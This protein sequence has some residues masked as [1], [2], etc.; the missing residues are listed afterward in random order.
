MEIGVHE[1]KTLPYSEVKTVTLNFPI[2]PHATCGC[3]HTLTYT[4]THTHT[5]THTETP[6]NLVC[7]RP[8]LGGN[9][10]HLP[11]QTNCHLWYPLGKSPLEVWVSPETVSPDLGYSPL[12]GL[13]GPEPQHHWR[14]QKN[15]F[16]YTEL[17]EI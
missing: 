9:P 13:L 6:E 1:K 4:H 12:C 16:L 3:T 5:H 15:I 8:R 11:F 17:V 2:N 7:G 10:L 14:Q